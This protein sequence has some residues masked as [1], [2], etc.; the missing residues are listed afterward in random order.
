[1]II[2][3]LQKSG[4][5]SLDPMSNSL[6]YHTTTST[7]S[8]KT[9]NR[10]VESSSCRAAGG[11]RFIDFPRVGVSDTTHIW[12]PRFWTHLQRKDCNTRFHHHHPQQKPRRRNSS[13]ARRWWSQ[14]YHYHHHHHYWRTRRRFVIGIE[15]KN[16]A[17]FELRCQND[18]AMTDD[19]PALVRRTIRFRYWEFFSG[20][21]DGTMTWTYDKKKRTMW[22]YEINNVAQ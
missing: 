22:K 10:V 1:M 11:E 8:R 18:D 20:F 12:N 16:N 7:N 4:K 19:C 13:C 9:D 17:E 3:P 5:I 15:Y 2:S 6:N 14:Y 21:K